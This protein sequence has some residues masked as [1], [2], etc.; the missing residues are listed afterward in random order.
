[1]NLADLSKYDDVVHLTDGRNSG[2]MEGKTTV[3]V[4]ELIN[5]VQNCLSKG[6]IRSL[7][8]DISLQCRILQSNQGKWQKGKL[9][10][11]FEFVP[12]ESPKTEN[13]LDELRKQN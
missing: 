1:M 3:F 9:I 7:A 6:G 12:D 11:R 2:F 13:E 5:A 4:G 10:L 8:E